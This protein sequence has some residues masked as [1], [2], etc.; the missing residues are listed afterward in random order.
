M[1]GKILP[2]LA[3]PST[4]RH[5]ERRILR[6]DPS[7]L[8]D[9]IVDVDSYSAF[10]PLC[11]RSKVLRRSECG[12]QFDAVLRVGLGG[13]VGVTGGPL[14]TSATAL[15][16][17][18]YVSRVTADRKAGT[19]EANSIRSER[20]DGLRSAWRLR[21]LP[22]ID[23]AADANFEFGGNRWTDVSFEVEM[24]VSDPLIACTINA[25]LGEVAARQVEAFER[26][27]SHLAT[28][29]RGGRR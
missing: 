10:L 18:E 1:L 6:V 3:A 25:V 13:G 9:V 2:V 12:R 7:H 15:I 17:E 16:S 26:R 22:A 4:Q 23:S 27:C 14:A 11:T 8:F 5:L 29:E 28:V 20:L 24:T 19:I 21:P